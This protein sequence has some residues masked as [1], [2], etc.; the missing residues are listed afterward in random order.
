MP[1]RAVL[2]A[3]ERSALLAFPTEPDALIRHYTFDE[4]DLTRIRRHRGGHNRLG[5]AV[6]LCCLRFPG[7]PLTPDAIPPDPLLDWVAR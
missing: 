2:T 4:R 6:Q 3:A 7:T 1:W 5:F